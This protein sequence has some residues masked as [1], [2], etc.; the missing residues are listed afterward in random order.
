MG[1]KSTLCTWPPLCLDGI[2]VIKFTK[3]KKTAAPLF[4]FYG[5][6]YHYRGMLVGSAFRYTASTSP[7]S[8]AA[9]WKLWDAF[10]IEDADMIGWWEDAEEGNGTAPVHA[11]HPDF[12]CTSYVKKG[13]ATLVAVA[14]W[15]DSTDLANHTSQVM[16]SHTP[17]LPRR[18]KWGRPLFC[19]LRAARLASRAPSST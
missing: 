14:E 17:S 8:P 12:L 16:P 18:E 13:E 9:L 5:W 2:V 4:L 10:M 19:F 6:R 7:F 1:K 11:S 15:Q 3:S